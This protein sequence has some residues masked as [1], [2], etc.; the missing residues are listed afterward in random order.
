MSSLPQ[1]KEGTTLEKKDLKGKGKGRNQQVV[2]SV[3]E[4]VMGKV[5]AEEVGVGAGAELA[6]I[7]G[8]LPKVR[9][10]WLG[11]SEDGGRGELEH[12]G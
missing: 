7:A 12:Q 5:R 3:L 8:A 2:G 10:E 6:S 11:Q 1:T 4:E 9:K